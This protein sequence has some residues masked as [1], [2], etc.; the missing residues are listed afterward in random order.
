MPTHVTNFQVVPSPPKPDKKN[1]CD[2]KKPSGPDWDN[3]NCTMD[4][5]VDVFEQAGANVTKGYVGGLDSHGT[6]IN[7]TYNNAGLCPVNVHWHIGAEHY[8]QGEFDD[9][10]KGPEMERDRR[11][12]LDVRAGFRCHHFDD[13]DPKFT[14][15][16]DWQHCEHMQVGETYEVHWPHSKAGACGTPFQYQT[17]FY[18]GVFCNGAE[19]TDT[20]W[21]DIGVQS[22]VFTIVNDEDYFFPDLMRGMIV[23]G[24]YGMDIAKYTGS[25]TGTSRDNTICSAY[26]PITWQVD[27]RCHLISA[28]T[29]DKMCADMKQQ[30]DDMSA[31][32]EPHGA[33]MLVTHE[34]AADNMERRV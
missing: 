19:L 22:Q 8:S 9:R 15:P 26:S 12:G 27:R 28:S 10:G 1:P 24:N 32:L 13:S 2:G 3:K 34:L 23:D 6:P 25:T 16:Y 11:L 29:F 33:R 21:L 7:D 31:D 30:F 17:P 4:D 20:Y 18:D 5:I 14:T